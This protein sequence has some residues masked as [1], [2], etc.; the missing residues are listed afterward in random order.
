MNSEQLQIL[1]HSLG[2]D[3][4][5][6]GESYRNYFVASE[7][8]HDWENLLWLVAAAMMTRRA[9]NDLSGGG[10]VFHVT[11]AGKRAVIEHSPSRPKRTVAQERY[12]AWLETD[13]GIPFGEWLRRGLYRGV[14][15]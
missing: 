14:P 10:D 4:Y 15:A 8:H 5:G 13:C 1:Q 12:D 9:G 6:Q 11:D 7:G 2:L 3:E